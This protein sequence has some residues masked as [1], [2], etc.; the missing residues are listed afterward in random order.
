MEN[1][2]MGVWVHLLPKLILLLVITV[3]I[4]IVLTIKELIHGIKFR[5]EQKGWLGNS[6]EWEGFRINKNWAEIIDGKLIWKEPIIGEPGV[7]GVSGFTMS[8]VMQTSNIK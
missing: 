5:K 2:W 3:S 1:F 8:T 4:I 7:K 6:F